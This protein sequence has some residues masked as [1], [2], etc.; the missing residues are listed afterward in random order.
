MYSRVRQPLYPWL[1]A[2]NHGCLQH[3]ELAEG[4]WF[5]GRGVLSMM[6]RLAF[7]AC[8]ALSEHLLGIAR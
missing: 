4:S 7:P 3:T 6:R 2:C 8:D 5:G 1:S